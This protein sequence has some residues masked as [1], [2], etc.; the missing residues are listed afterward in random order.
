MSNKTEQRTHF[1]CDRCGQMATVEGND[2]QF[3]MDWT[4]TDIDMISDKSK[5]TNIHG[6]RDLCPECT[7][8]F[9]ALYFKDKQ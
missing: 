2:S 1:T 7:L 9:I 5:A 8:E 4:T 6:S 3:P